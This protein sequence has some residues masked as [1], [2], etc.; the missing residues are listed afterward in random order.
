MYPS[1]DSSF[2]FSACLYCPGS[3][4]KFD[5]CAPGVRGIKL[6]WPFDLRRSRQ[7]LSKSHPSNESAC[8]VYLRS[9]INFLQIAL[10]VHSDDWGGPN[11]LELVRIRCGTDD[12]KYTVANVFVV[13]P[14]SMCLEY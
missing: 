4:D 3:I 8:R 5:G 7:K 10:S 11:I 6:N 9:V 14:L 12:V 1:T 13:R 2:I